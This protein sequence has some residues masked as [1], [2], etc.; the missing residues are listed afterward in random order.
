MDDGIGVVG[1]EHGR[2][3]DVASEFKDGFGV[4]FVESVDDDGSL[5]FSQIHHPVLAAE[6]VYSFQDGLWISLGR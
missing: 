6:N 3:A 1:H 5:V 4:G 2:I